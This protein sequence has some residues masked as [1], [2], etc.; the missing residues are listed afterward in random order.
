MYEKK[1]IEEIERNRCNTRKFFNE[2][3]S[4]KTGFKPQTRILSDELRNANHRREENSEPFQRLL[5]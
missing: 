5:Y 4:I 3:G 2:N 1:K